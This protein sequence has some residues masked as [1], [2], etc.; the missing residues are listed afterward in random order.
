MTAQLTG[1][2]SFATPR[3]AWPA[4]MDLMDLI[5]TPNQFR[6]PEAATRT[7]R[8]PVHPG[9]QDAMRMMSYI[10]RQRR[11]ACPSSVNTPP[12]LGVTWS[13]ARNSV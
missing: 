11:A 7:A 8:L 5:D 10:C 12:L 1:T 4:L 9:G 6:S 2:S 3:H 13:K